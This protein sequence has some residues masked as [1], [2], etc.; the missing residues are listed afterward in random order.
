MR[1]ETFKPKRAEVAALESAYF[2]AFKPVVD[3]LTGVI[4]RKVNKAL[5]RL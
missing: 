3:R 1:W 5:L 2:Q 4:E